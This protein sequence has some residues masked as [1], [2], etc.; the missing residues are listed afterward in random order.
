MDVAV[1]MVGTEAVIAHALGAIAEFQLRVIRVRPPAYGALAGVGLGV[2][3]VF[4]ALVISAEPA[5]GAAVPH[6]QELEGSQQAASAEQEAVGE[7][8][9]RQESPPD[10]HHHQ[11]IGGFEIRDPFDLDGDEEEQQE[12]IVRP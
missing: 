9:Q 12:L 8:R 2:L 7:A 5:G 6:A 4:G 10:D 1:D 3:P 11:I